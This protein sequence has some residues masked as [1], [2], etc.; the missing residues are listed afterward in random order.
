VIYYHSIPYDKIN[1][2][3][4]QINILNKITTP[5]P[6]SYE[7]SLNNKLRYSI[8]TFDDAFR[9]IINNGVPVLEK[10]K[11]PFTVFIPAG[12]LG[13]NP[14]W[15]KNTGRK[16]E[17]DVVASIEELLRIPSEITTFGSH[18]INHYDLTQIKYK[19]ALTEI[20]DSKKI[21]ESILKKE[22]N[23]FSFPY[24]R[25]TG[26][27]VEC[28]NEAGYNQVFG[29]LPESPLAP[30]KK[31]VKG[32]IRVDPDDWYI[33]FILKILGGYGWRAFPPSIKQRFKKWQNANHYKTSYH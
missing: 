10:A 23:C 5:I 32:R 4:K 29:I 6:L 18:T 13:K 11:T 12:Q 2:F 22:I 21:L 30:L 20:R 25:Y 26:K 27:I 14:G 15:L 9:S 17:F 1:R 3:K 24:G 31:Y 16:D 33:E 19:E 8:I 7:G 28:C